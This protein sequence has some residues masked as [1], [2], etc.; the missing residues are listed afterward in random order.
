M[1]VFEKF[2]PIGRIDWSK[3]TDPMVSTG[4]KLMKQIEEF[5]F[6]AYIVGGAVRD[7]AMGDFDVHDIDIATNMPIDEIKDKFRTYEYGGGERHGTVIVHMGSFDYE[8][9]QFRTEGAYS[10]KRRPDSVEFVQSF[11]EDTKRR[12]FTINSMGIDSNGTFIDYHGGLSDIEHGILKTVGDAKERFDEDA[13]R[14]L[15]AIRFASRFGFTI[16][17]LTLQAMIDLAHTVTSTSIERIRDELFKTISYGSDKFS[18]ALEL[19]DACGLWELIVPEIKLTGE[20][21]R[22]LHALDTKVPEK[23]FAVL[24]QDMTIKTIELLCKRLTFTLKEMKTISFIVSS[25]P[26]Y[27][28]LESIDRQTALSIVTHDD[29]DSLREVYIAVFSLDIK[30]SLEIIAKISTFSAVR[31]RMKEIN[32]LIQ[33]EGLVGIKFGRMA[34]M[35]FQWLFDEYA[36]GEVHSSE[37]IKLFIYKNKG[38]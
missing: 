23:V 32:Q 28:E 19:M 35:I 3:F 15:R 21:I 27:T 20:K 8:L 10:D 7:I 17:A 13:L 33:E 38:T 37:D 11:E 14:I 2:E 9:T 34:H 25:M 6:E 36:I 31:S 22:S 30:N 29:F 1:T 4:V 12:D 18:C 26:L 5:G 16:D 24:M